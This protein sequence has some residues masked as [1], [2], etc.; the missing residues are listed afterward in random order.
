MS[1]EN[2]PASFLVIIYLFQSSASYQEHSKQ[3]SY[4]RILFADLIQQD[5][6]EE[7]CKEAIRNFWENEIAKCPQGAIASLGR[8]CYLKGLLPNSLYIEAEVFH[9]HDIRR[10]WKKVFARMREF[11]KMDELYGELRKTRS[12]RFRQ[13]KGNIS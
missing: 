12:A 10:V 11:H 9:N 3:E 2:T 13:L 4:K 8:L 6:K 1:S 5:S 7:A